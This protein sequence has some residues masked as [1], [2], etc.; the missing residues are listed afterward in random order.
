MSG[1]DPGR[2]SSVADVA[3]SHCAL[4][5]YLT[6]STMLRVCPQWKSATSATLL[7]QK[8]PHGAP[9]S[10][11]ITALRSAV[12]REIKLSLAEAQASLQKSDA[13]A[14]ESLL[15][16]ITALQKRLH[17]RRSVVLAARQASLVRG[18][19]RRQRRQRIPVVWG[20]P[21][22]YDPNLMGDRCDVCRHTDSWISQPTKLP[23]TLAW[24]CSACPPISKE[25]PH[26]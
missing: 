15:G 13:D 25:I 22:G 5:N 10:R 19:Q 17:N 9:M 16:L 26:D 20:F 2:C 6:Q 11:P 1:S 24:S 21:T 18:I 3:D 23:N 12:A 4:S 14:R 7:H 8:T